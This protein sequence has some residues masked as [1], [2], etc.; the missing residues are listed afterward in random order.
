VF[1]RGTPRL[2]PL[3]PLDARRTEGALLD[4]GRALALVIGERDAE[5]F[6][7]R[8]TDPAECRALGCGFVRRCFGRGATMVIDTVPDGPR[9]TAGA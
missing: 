6:P 7:R 1:V 9:H 8:P 5:A 2:V 4:A 3:P